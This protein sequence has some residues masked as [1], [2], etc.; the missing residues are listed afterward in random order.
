MSPLALALNWFEKPWNTTAFGP[1][2]ETTQTEEQFW[3][4]HSQFSS[5][6]THF[7]IHT[8][9]YFCFCTEME[10][11]IHYD[12]CHVFNRPCRCINF[13]Q[14]HMKQK[15]HFVAMHLR[16]SVDFHVNNNSK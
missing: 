13:N 2:L 7:K 6:E 12:S 1:I 9:D 5:D 15:D 11:I 16:L 10:K 3:Q 14:S 4:I 8:F